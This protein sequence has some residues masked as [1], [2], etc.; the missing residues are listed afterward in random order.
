MKK[1]TDERKFMLGIDVG[2]TTV[3][4]VLIDAS[5]DEVLWQ[6]YQ[7]HD[8]R[9]AEKVLEY[10]QLLEKDYQISTHNCRLFLTG[11][12]A[13]PLT[14]FI[15]GKFVQE[16]NAVS[17]AVE[18]FYPEAGSVIELGGQDAK[19]LI[20]KEVLE[21]GRKKK[22]FS[23]NDK[24]AGGTGAV[25]D[26]ISAKLNI[27]A[28][29]L[30]QQRYTGY[31]IHPVAG[32]CGVF[33]ETDINGLQKVGVPQDELMASLF[34]A[35]VEQNLSVLTRGNTLR[36]HVLLL[37]GPNTFIQGMHECWRA[38]ITRLWQERKFSLDE[39]DVP[40]EEL[41]RVPDNGQYFAAR[42]AVEFGKT[43]GADVGIYQGLEPLVHYLEVGRIEKMKGTCNA[44]KG[45]VDNEEE[46]A[47]FS[48]TYR[49]PSFDAPVFSQGQK[50]KGF[51]GIDGGSTSTKAVLMDTDSQVIAL[52]YQLSK[53]NPISDTIEVL[54]K[55]RQQVESDGAHLE[56]LGL[57]TTGYAKD[58]LADVLN[59]DVAIVETVAHSKSA[60][61]YYD[62]VDVIC[63]VGGQDIKI[64]MLK[65]GA[66]KDFKINTQCSAGNGYFLHST[67]ET[68]NIDLK[69]YA[70]KAFSAKVMPCF[71]YGC[72][73]FMQ[74]DIVNFQRQGWQAEE[75]LAGLADVLPKNI[76]LY[77][78]QIPN[79]PKLGTKFIL[80]GGTQRN[81]AAV[82]AQ[83]DFIRS[84]FA[85]LEEE[86]EITVHKFCGESGAIGA[87]L[88]SIR[89]W[90][91]GKQTS[92]IGFKA[93]KD[94]TFVTHRN[95][96]TRCHFCKNLCL[97]S[98]IDVTIPGSNKK[99]EPSEFKSKIQLG[100]DAQRLIVSNSCERGL[101]ED[102]KQM[103]VIQAD[104]TQVKSQNPNLAE[105]ASKAAFWPYK[106]PLV[107]DSPAR[108][109]FLAKQ[110]KR[111]TLMNRRK[112]IKIGI[113]RV[114]NLYSCNPFFSGYFESLGV[115][116]KNL[117]YS[118]YTS[119]QL[120]KEGNKRGSV[121]PCFPSKVSLAHI[122]NLLF[123]KNLK[124]PLDIIFFPMIATL[125]N[126]ELKGAIGHC[127]CP[128]VTT[129]PESVKSGFTNESDLFKDNGVR[130]LNTYVS[131]DD[132]GRL[133]DQMYKEFK[134]IFGLSHAENNRAVEEGYK[135]LDVFLERKLRDPARQL[136]KQLEEEQRVGIVLLGRPY[137]NDPGLNHGILEEFQKRGY[138]IFTQYSLPTN[139][140]ILDKLFAEDIA[141]GRIA[142]PT[143]I[144][145]VWQVSYSENSSHKIWVAKYVARHPNLVGLDLSSFKCGHDA[146][147]YTVVEEILENSGTPYFSFKDLDENKPTG[148]IKLRI[149]TIDY[150]LRRY[151]EDTLENNKAYK[152]ASAEEIDSE[153]VAG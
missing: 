77:V 99:S 100:Q 14:E 49:V 81:L 40:P 65:N 113:P 12:G 135:A 95:E 114:L 136:L 35:I 44:Q 120:Y 8:T 83:V 1:S 29:E 42:G 80:Q 143:D 148:S 118:D 63:D 128:T 119:E 50:V 84:R 130:F 56:V 108:F 142:H 88:E 103:L 74:T 10:L 138:P 111:Q 23:M 72:A 107:A 90:Q 20:Y 149:E 31:K 43:E 96:N 124:T 68:F 106:P 89:L 26:K 38:A 152:V 24:C 98:F 109:S 18:K 139:P 151:R 105:L 94:I 117:I 28:E 58:I 39:Y 79:I 6:N 47:T 91:N 67:A 15:G 30:S 73:V 57:G 104:V 110:K 140:E 87:A 125:P 46:L 27:P 7:R 145:D 86:P 62:D 33:A 131:L 93:V 129:T 122:H 82:K 126:S 137:H 54:E 102:E 16:V 64:M 66:V 127:A 22:I 3:K 9:Q 69:E 115:N 76:W 36:P 141:S 101:V 11:S 37:G 25:I 4:S 70:D 17:M 61:H 121:D 146:P 55:L 59:A 133:K 19:I 53:G 134:S 85:G 41:I 116:P 150:F 32:K 34:E 51:I 5:S 60:L 2:S 153:L 48:E 78:A 144:S 123:V 71:G 52:T 75:I 13:S 97:R 132:P 112:N 21:D 45:L 92:F 147:I